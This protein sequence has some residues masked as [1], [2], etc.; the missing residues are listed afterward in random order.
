MPGC[1][2]FSWFLLSWGTYIKCRIPG[3]TPDPVTP[4]QG[5]GWRESGW[6]KSISNKL[7]AT[8]TCGQTGTSPQDGGGTRAPFPFFPLLRG[9]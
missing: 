6:Q 1:G 4:T 3:S 8:L 9:H 7:P 5:G 2:S